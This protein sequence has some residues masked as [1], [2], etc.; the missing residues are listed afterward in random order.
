MINEA[1][2]VGNWTVIIRL[3]VISKQM[4]LYTVV[5]KDLS[6]VICIGN[7]L[8]WAK[9]RALHGNRSLSRSKYVK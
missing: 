5:G 7:E 8:S 6:S 9:T 4:I 2:N 3:S 1:R